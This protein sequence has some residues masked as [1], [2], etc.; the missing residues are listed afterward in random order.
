MADAANHEIVRVDA[1]VAR[2]PCTAGFVRVAQEGQA[3]RFT[4]AEGGYALE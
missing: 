4:D 3:A 1:D 2:F